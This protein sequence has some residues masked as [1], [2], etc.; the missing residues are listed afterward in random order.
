MKGDVPLMTLSDW[1]TLLNNYYKGNNFIKKTEKNHQSLL[2]TV[3]KDSIPP[4]IRPHAYLIFS[5]GF[6]YLKKSLTGEEFKFKFQ[7]I[8]DNYLA[9]ESAGDLFMNEE[10][11]KTGEYPIQNKPRILNILSQIEKD[12]NRTYFPQDII[13]REYKEEGIEMDHFE[14]IEI[15]EKEIEKMKKITKEV[16][17]CYALANETVEYVQGMNS[18]AAEL[19]IIILCLKKSLNLKKMWKI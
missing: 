15:L 14:E 1:I 4:I 3:I 16:L 9:Q 2:K 6:L 5:G 8:Y 17:I 18:I 7:D 10:K 12:L 11:A 19:F 13:I